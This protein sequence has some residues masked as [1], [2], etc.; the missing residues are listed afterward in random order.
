VLADHRLDQ[1]RSQLDV[2]SEIG[3]AQVQICRWEKGHSNPTIG[4]LIAYA[5][6]LGC[7]ITVAP[8][9]DR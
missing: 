8:K 2:A 3:V 5:E 1:D 7:V 6:A 9:A 4:H